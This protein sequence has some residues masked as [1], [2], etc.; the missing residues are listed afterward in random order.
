MT[1][2]SSLSAALF[3]VVF[4]AGCLDF[5]GAY[6]GYCDAG[7]C[8]QDDGGSGGGSGGS[9]GGT[10]GSGGTG[11]GTGGSG[12]GTG[13]AGGGTGGS[14]GAG[15]GTGGTGG[16]GG[17]GADPLLCDAGLCYVRHYD[18]PLRNMEA[19]HQAAP[20][21]V[22]AG[23]L[24]G[25]T[26]R[27]DGTGFMP[28]QL[29]QT[30]GQV[31]AI[32]GTGPSDYYAVGS[33]GSVIHRWDGANWIPHQGLLPSY[34]YYGV[35]AP[36]PGRALAASYDTHVMSWDGAAWTVAASNTTFGSEDIHGCN[37]SEAWLPTYEG[38]IM[39]YTPDGGLRLIY[40]GGTALSSVWCHPVGGVWVVGYSGTVLRSQPDG[41]FAAFDA[42]IT[43]NLYTVWVSD[44]G[45]VWMGGSVRTLIRYR[46]FGAGARTAYNVAPF[47]LGYYTDLSGLNDELWLTGN[48]APASGD[49]GAVVQYRVGP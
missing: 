31:W 47:G 12:G 17:G 4:C 38:K 41:G 6:N 26:I 24:G 32:S 15:G 34:S 44:A 29:P 23:A 43:N 35:W 22:F 49:G 40:D 39:R 13:G 3:T 16:A 46:N 5:D 18:T 42:G 2:I 28:F 8:A 14:G 21:S 30:T 27:W 9:G 7:R 36:A 48:Y 37:Q 10:G 11:G 25:I 33:P 20:N 19:V 45:D 1:R